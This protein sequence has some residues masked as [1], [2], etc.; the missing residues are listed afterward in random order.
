M[1]R[2]TGYF[3]VARYLQSTSAAR[4]VEFKY[5]GFF[6]GYE[7]ITGKAFIVNLLTLHVANVAREGEQNRQRK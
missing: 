3:N 4:F 1:D 6:C 2:P 7:E 5:G